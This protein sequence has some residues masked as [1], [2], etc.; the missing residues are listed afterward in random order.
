MKF[1]KGRFPNVLQPFCIF[2]FLYMPSAWVSRLFIELDFVMD[3]RIFFFDFVLAV[4]KFGKFFFQVYT[5]SELSASIYPRWLLPVNVGSPL[6]RL[7]IFLRLRRLVPIEEYLR[8]PR[9]P[10][11]NDDP[12]FYFNS[13]STFTGCATFFGGSTKFDY[14]SALL[15]SKENSY[16]LFMTVWLFWHSEC[17]SIISIRI[18]EM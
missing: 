14:N 1:Y 13:T 2:E 6:D 5:H 9:L 8:S 4:K 17:I 18:F 11:T 15:Y 10:E 7:G 3:R 12:Y 16:G